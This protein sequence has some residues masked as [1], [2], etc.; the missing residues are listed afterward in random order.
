[1]A[2]SGSKRNIAANVK[3]QQLD[4]PSVVE[5]YGADCAAHA[6]EAGVLVVGAQVQVGRITQRNVRMGEA[7]VSRRRHP[8][9]LLARR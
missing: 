7:P 4:M 3:P 8:R 6:V 1:M 5:Q 2:V 9:L